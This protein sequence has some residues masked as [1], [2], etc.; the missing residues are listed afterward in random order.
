M[1]I[2]WAVTY[3]VTAGVGEGLF[4]PNGTV[5]RA[6]IITFLH[7]LVAL[8]RLSYLD[9]ARSPAPDP[10]EGFEAATVRM[11][12]Y[13]CC[14]DLA[15]WQIPIEKGWLEDLNIRID[16]PGG[17]MFVTSSETVAALQ[18]GDLDVVTAW[19]P[20]ALERIEID[21]QTFPPV[22][23]ADI[24]AGYM[25]LVAPDSPAKTALEFMEEGMSFT[26]AAKAAVEQLVR[27]DIYIPPYSTTSSQYADAFF[28][29]LD[30]W[31][32]EKTRIPLLDSDGT[33][34]VLM[35]RDGTSLLDSGGRAQPITITSRD[36][37]YYATP[38]YN[39]DL[40]T[41][42]LSITT[43]QIEFAMPYNGNHLTQMIHNG[44]DP[45]I[46][47][48]ML[49]KHDPAS[50]PTSLAT[51]PS[52]GNTGLLANRK[53]VAQNR[54][55][56]FRLLS[57]AYRTLGYINDPKTQS[58]GWT[59]E[60]NLINDRRH[61]NLMA[62]H[63]GILWDHLHP[64]FTWEDQEALWSLDLPGFHAETSLASRIEELK[65]T[66]VLSSELDIQTALDEFLL[67]KELYF[68]M[69]NMQERS[70]E[71]LD[72][73][74]ASVLSD[75]QLLWVEKARTFYEQCNFYDSLRYLE[76]ALSLGSAQ[77]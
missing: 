6:Q 50:Y 71:L 69:R 29:Y 39:Q 19:I 38:R 49:Y 30:E 62:D 20:H 11:G 4:D 64:S 75:I 36:W 40:T 8:V 5:T 77:P 13:P 35:N 55:T 32:Q 33:P 68:E 66:G 10:D 7:R 43:G 26:E 44:W 28:A 74:K 58:E 61:L 72:R 21:G 23:V 41:L 27:R 60:A 14:A 70:D 16:P 73:A 31:G 56:V 42:E 67:A 17:H 47:Y 57:V 37:R 22:L 53:W 9:M 18:Q 63:I 34:V 48:A 3:G 1:E 52:V 59:I 45:L 76:A 54:D 2:G 25:I 12:I 51:G 24:Y 65:E 46:S 15:F